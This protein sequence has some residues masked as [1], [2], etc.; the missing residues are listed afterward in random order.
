MYAGTPDT[1]GGLLPVVVVQL[2]PHTGGFELRVAA[3]PLNDDGA[4]PLDRLF[5][6]DHVSPHHVTVV[7]VPAAATV[8]SPSTNAP[9]LGNA[10]AVAVLVLAEDL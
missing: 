8:L 5:K 3:K 6:L 4:D 10:N 7:E 1:G 9:R 2:P